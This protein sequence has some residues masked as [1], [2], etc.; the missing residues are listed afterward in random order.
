METK[1]HTM[2]NGQLISVPHKDT[3]RLLE[4]YVKRSLSVNDGNLVEKQEARKE[5]WV[6]KKHRRHSSDPS[7][8]HL[9]DGEISTAV[10]APPDRPE[11]RPGVPEKPGKKPKKSKKPS[12]WKGLFNILSRKSNEDKDDEQ[13]SAPEMPE[14][15][16]GDN[17]SEAPVTCLPTPTVTMQKK[18]KST[19]K[20]STR[21][22][23]SKRFKDVADI[24][25]VEGKSGPRHSDTDY[26]LSLNIQMCCFAAVEPTYSYYE[27]VSEELE[28]IVHEVKEEVQPL[29]NGK[30]LFT[31]VFC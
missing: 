20:R 17:V 29:S 7:L 6:T 18:K 22:R 2:I 14:N 1:R 3:I 19:R 21:R 31:V 8:S 12:F 26:Y 27:K 9:D 5:K 10:E 15:L 4:V 16:E 13:D 30:R 24:T 25:G 28:K 23:L 11:A